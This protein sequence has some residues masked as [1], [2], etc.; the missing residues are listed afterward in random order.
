MQMS[1]AKRVSLSVAAVLAV[2][3]LALAPLPVA[4]SNGKFD[5]V[6]AELAKAK[7]CLS[8]HDGLAS[9]RADTSYFG[10][11]WIEGEAHD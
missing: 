1:Y 9:M 3:T 8:C 5:S 2:A 4:A 6:S 7:G 11:T 10:W